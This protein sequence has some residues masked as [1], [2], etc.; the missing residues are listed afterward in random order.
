MPEI[1]ESP[2]YVTFINVFEV[3]PED[4]PDVV[5][6]LLETMEVASKCEGFISASA[7]RS[8]D[9][10]HVFTYLQW[11]RP[12]DLRAYQ[13]SPEFQEIAPRFAGRIQFESF[14]C[15]VVHVAEA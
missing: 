14:Q 15:D 3:R 5:K 6:I 10:T 13:A 11:R 9:G 7:H 12:E 8:L 4:Q 1:R 2:D